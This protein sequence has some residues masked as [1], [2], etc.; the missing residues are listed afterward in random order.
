MR[1]CNFC[2]K[3]TLGD[4]LF[5]NYCGRSYDHK[6]CP[7]KHPNPRTA[8]VCSQCGSRDFSIPQPPL[9]F[10][11]GPFLYLLS[12]LPGFLLLGIS[13]LFLI[14]FIQMLITNQQMMGQFMSLGLV[15]GLAWFG[16]M[17]LP[18]FIRNALRKTVGRKGRGKED[19]H[20]H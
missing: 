11:L 13:I 10:W 14:G 2:R 7:A 5:C 12:L 19:K 16:Y 6:L 20:G 1:Y 15:I 3:V 9:P 8:Q 18:H 17:Q 4:P